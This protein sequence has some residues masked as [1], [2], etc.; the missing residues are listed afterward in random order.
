MREATAEIRPRFNTPIALAQLAEGHCACAGCDA[1]VSPDTTWGGT[2]WLRCARCGC[3][4]K[5][6][7]FPIG[8]RACRVPSGRCG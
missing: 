1:L 7:V 2:G 8:R 6:D 3:M 4:W 5:A